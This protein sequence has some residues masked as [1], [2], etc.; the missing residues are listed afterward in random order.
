MEERERYDTLHEL[1]KE[2]SMIQLKMEG[3]K[4][5][6]ERAQLFNRIDEVKSKMAE[7][8]KLGAGEKVL[9]TICRPT[10]LKKKKSNELSGTLPAPFLFFFFF[11]WGGG[12]GGWI[13]YVFG[14]HDNAIPTDSPPPPHHPSSEFAPWPLTNC[15]RL[16]SPFIFLYI[17]D[18]GPGIDPDH[19]VIQLFSYTNFC[20]V[21]FDRDKSHM[22][23]TKT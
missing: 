1:E 6:Q 18:P 22:N 8:E 13:G 23:Y 20:I 16:S 3:M 21:V 12:G 9:N 11:F 2:S 19:F 5:R 10:P 14:P 15:L 7:L 4:W 17:L